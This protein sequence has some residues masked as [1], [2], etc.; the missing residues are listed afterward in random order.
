MSRTGLRFEAFGLVVALG[1]SMQATV[2]P[3]VQRHSADTFKV[4][5]LQDSEYEQLKRRFKAELKILQRWQ[6]LAAKTLKT[7][8]AMSLRSVSGFMLTGILEPSD[9]IQSDAAEILE[10]DKLVS[11]AALRETGAKV[12]T[13]SGEL[14]NAAQK[15]CDTMQR[16]ISSELSSQLGAYARGG[17]E[18]GV[19]DTKTAIAKVRQI[20][21]CPTD[22]DGIERAVDA[23]YSV[24]IEWR[25]GT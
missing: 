19:A 23:L 12:A 25:K 15:D 6:K 8:A 1:Y 20:G 11:L 2:A 24:L 21:A 4:I 17:N 9:K 5:T 22:P 18:R 13:A 10:R 3:Q 14:Q 16:A 7:G